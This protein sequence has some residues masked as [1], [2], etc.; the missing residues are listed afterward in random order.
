MPATDSPGRKDALDP[1]PVDAGWPNLRSHTSCVDIH[2]L[3]AH[4]VQERKIS[5]AYFEFGVAGGESAIAAIRAHR[6]YNPHTV[7]PFLL[8][9]TFQG[10]PALRG[11]DW[12]STQFS[13]KQL[14]YSVEQV[15]TRLSSYDVYEPEQVHL[16]PGR[17]E[18]SL[19]AFPATSLGVT[20]AAVVHLNLNDSKTVALAL[21]FIHDFL[22]TG[23]VILFDNWN[24]TGT[25]SEKNVRTAALEWL[26]GHPGWGLQEYAAYGSHGQACRLE[27]IEQTSDLLAGS[28]ADCSS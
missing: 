15:I 4:S 17:F 28:R 14:S 20:T 27:V 2:S 5:G 13:Q 1:L 8:F 23:T 21:E 9:D 26:Q 11:L 22:Q 3:V 16:L 7:G 6:R 25:N 12:D 18:Q 10:L 19:P 24:A